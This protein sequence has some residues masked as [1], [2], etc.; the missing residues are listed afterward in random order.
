[1]SRGLEER[2]GCL[3]HAGASDDSRLLVYEVAYTHRHVSLFP[4]S[5]SVSLTVIFTSTAPDELSRT[6]RLVGHMQPA[7]LFCTVPIQ[8]TQF[9]AVQFRRNS[10]MTEFL[11]IL[12][13][14][15]FVKGTQHSWCCFQLKRLTLLGSR[16]SPVGIATRKVA[17]RSGDRITLG[18][19]FTTPFQTVPGAHM[20]SCSVR[21]ESFTRVIRPG[22]DAGYPSPS[23]AEF[24]NGLE[25]Y[26]CFPLL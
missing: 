26:L 5:V 16:D 23:S 22:S 15:F 10:R 1:M 2:A 9:G 7:N 4:R 24:A 25:V 13:F 11:S 14:G 6:T 8:D 17:G 20:T 12:Y 18:A 21:T 3:C 19:R